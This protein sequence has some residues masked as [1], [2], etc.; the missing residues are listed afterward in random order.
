MKRVK[1]YKLNSVKSQ[2]HSGKIYDPF[3]WDE[4][5]DRYKN[6]VWFGGYVEGI[7]YIPRNISVVG[8][9]IMILP[10]SSDSF[11]D[12]PYWNF[13]SIEET[14]QNICYDGGII[15]LTDITVKATIV[16]YKMK[17]NVGITKRNND[18]TCNT[19]VFLNVNNC[20]Q[21]SPRYLVDQSNSN[22]NKIFSSEITFDLPTG[23]IPS[24]SISL[25]IQCSYVHNNNSGVD[26]QH[27]TIYPQW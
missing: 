16:Y 7:G 20:P 25:D 5:I 12:Y 13:T 8:S 1:V 17:I 24:P 4:F 21:I 23:F 11:E 18:D 14:F 2:E 27:F 26:T 9:T 6:G 15:Y 10:A 3:P 22:D 19:S